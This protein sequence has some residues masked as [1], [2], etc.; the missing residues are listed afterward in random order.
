MAFSGLILMGLNAAAPEATSMTVLLTSKEAG[1]PTLTTYYGASGESLRATLL[2]RSDQVAG[3]FGSLK[4]LT[5]LSVGK[6]QTFE[7][8]PR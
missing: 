8:S 1:V 7:I 2:I 6:R 3:E 4:I 5:G